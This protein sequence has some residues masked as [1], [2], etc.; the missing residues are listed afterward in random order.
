MCVCV[1]IPPGSEMVEAEKQGI[2]IVKS[3]YTIHFKYT[4][5]YFKP[6]LPFYVVVKHLFYEMHLIYTKSDQATYIKPIYRYEFCYVFDV[7][8]LIGSISMKQQLK[9]IIQLFPKIMN[10]RIN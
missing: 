4:S 9:R 1:F 10:E 5:K 2:Q 3:P 6:F 7:F 8:V